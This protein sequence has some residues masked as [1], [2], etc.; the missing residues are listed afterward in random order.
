MVKTTKT[1]P[2]L[3]DENNNDSNNPEAD[4]QENNNGQQPEEEPTEPEEVEVEF[5]SYDGAYYYDAQILDSYKRT[6][7]EYY[8]QYLENAGSNLE[9]TKEYVTNNYPT[10]WNPSLDKE[11]IRKV[12]NYSNNFMDAH[13]NIQKVNN[14]TLKKHKVSDVIYDTK[15]LY[16]GY[17]K[18]SDDQP[19]VKKQFDLDLRQYDMYT[20]GLYM[21]PGEA[22]TITFPGLTDEQVAALK[23]R[24]V[25]NDNEIKYLGLNNIETNWTKARTRMPVMRQEFTLTKNNFTYGNPLGG[26]INLEH[27]KGYDSRVNGSNIFR[28]VIDGAV[29]ALHY[30]HGYTTLE[31]WKR[32]AKESTAPF[33]EIAND[34]VKFLMAKSNLGPFANKDNYDWVLDENNN[35]ISYTPKEILINNTYPYKSLDLWNK[36]AYESRYVTGLNGNWIFKSQVKNYFTDFQHYVGGGAAFPW[37]GNNYNIMPRDWGSTIL[38]YDVNNNSGNW[39]VIHEYNH[40]FQFDSKYDYWGFIDNLYLTNNQVEVTNNVL[41][42]LSFAKYANMGQNRD[43]KQEVTNWPTG[44]LSNMNSYNALARV[45][46]SSTSSIRAA[47]TFDYTVVMANFGWEGLEK[48]IRLSNTTSAPSNLSKAYKAKFI[49][50][51]NKATNYNWTDF[52]Y[53]TGLLEESNKSTLNNLFKDLPKYVPIASWY[54]SQSKY[55]NSD[56]WVHSNQPF[57]ISKKYFN[58]GYKF[59]LNLNKTDQEHSLSSPTITLNPT[60][61]TLVNNGNGLYTYKPLL[62][63]TD[64]K[65]N[66][67]YNYGKVDSFEYSVDA[68]DY[69]TLKKDASA[70]FK[71]EIFLEGDGNENFVTKEEGMVDYQW[72]YDRN[73]NNV[74]SMTTLNISNIEA[75]VRDLKNID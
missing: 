40:H 41:N 30:I 12:I 56:T 14:N 62:T 71:V 23:I 8:P 15:N 37:S 43:G 47:Q 72:Y 35:V 6:V 9:P 55:N 4:D 39:G 61:G 52:Y 64:K 66:A 13:S 7:P 73:T 51:I 68:N 17:S 10:I 70:T 46:K 28:V 54:A 19:A 22:I 16:W 21:P 59:N 25:I 18:I 11:Q 75:A 27:I 50:F 2:L 33:V 49:Y 5:N 32:L 29:E 44:H 1:P 3:D 63:G 69:L 65:G 67:I 74:L 58:T 36:M 60:Y 24:L 34:N 42:L 45:I 48:A 31:E 57:M 20:T 26:M 38:D 53:Q